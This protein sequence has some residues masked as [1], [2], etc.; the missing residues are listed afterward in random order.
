MKIQLPVIQSQKDPRW[1]SKLIK[2][3]VSIGD[4]GCLASCQSMV[5]NYYGMNETPEELVGKINAKNGYTSDG[6]YYWG[7][8]VEVYKDIDLK[9]KYKRTNYVLTD[10]DINAIKGA[11]DQG[12]PVMVWLDYNPKTVKS[13]M[14]FVLIIGYNP[15]DENDFTIA[16]VNQGRQWKS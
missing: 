2:A 13:D 11:I 10:T 3:G 12:Y 7:K 4:Y 5:V 1:A 14:H 8:A 16:D 15:S 9:E 6:S